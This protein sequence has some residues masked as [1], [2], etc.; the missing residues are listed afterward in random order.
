MSTNNIDKPQPR[1]NLA[2][3]SVMWRWVK[4]LVTKGEWSG[5]Y[6]KL[7]SYE[8]LE[9]DS[10]G[11]WMAWK[12]PLMTRENELG[13]NTFECTPEESKKLAKTR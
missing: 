6:V 4:K 2:N 12:K 13:Y 8:F 5:N 11:V 7:P 10:S 3:N 1:I 9:E